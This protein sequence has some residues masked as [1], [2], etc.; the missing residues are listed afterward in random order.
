[1]FDKGFKLE[2]L[3]VFESLFFDFFDLI[4]ISFEEFRRVSIIDLVLLIF[5]RSMF[6]FILILIFE[7]F[8]PDIKFGSVLFILFVNF[9]F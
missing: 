5:G 7:L 2:N 4:L 1:M 8:I 3:T 9:I 6:I